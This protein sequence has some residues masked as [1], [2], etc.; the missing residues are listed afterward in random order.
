MAHKMHVQ[1]MEQL[2]TSKQPVQREK[3]GQEWNG[4]QL[5]ECNQI[6][7]KFSFRLAWLEAECCFM[8]MIHL[9]L[10]AHMP[11]AT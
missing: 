4:M 7:G 6:K 8:V 9:I 11:S 1:G 3:D 10:H 5:M 2:V